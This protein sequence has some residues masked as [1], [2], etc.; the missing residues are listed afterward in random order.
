MEEQ[1][2]DL[3]A[4]VAQIFT[5]AGWTAGT[6]DGWNGQFIWAGTVVGGIDPFGTPRVAGLTGPDGERP[7]VVASS[8]WLVEHAKQFAP[9]ITTEATLEPPVI[10][11]EQS[12]EPEESLGDESNGETGEEAQGAHQSHSSGDEASLAG[13]VE[14]DSSEGGP[15]D[16]RA[17]LGDEAELLDG[18]SLAP[19]DLPIDADF[20]EGQ[21]LGSELLDVE[22]ELS[23]PE[24]PSPDPE[25]F[26]PDEFAHEP[27][28]EPPQDRFI[29]LDDLDRVRSLRI[30]DVATEALRLTTLIEQA[31]SEQEGEF[32][33]IQAYVVSHL[34]KHTGAFTPQD[35]ASR[36]TYGRFLEL[37]SARSKIA[38]ID[39]RRKDATAFLLRADREQ[40]L[41]FGVA[42]AFA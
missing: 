41:S 2:R 20:T 29:G 27:E 11:L 22:S 9:V 24:L 17:D 36:A 4:E 34:D 35:D 32:S 15:D 25:D 42:A 31:V 26:A 14:V 7:E 28:P 3:P 40:V 39:A 21:D 19:T 30:G 10:V 33:N 6:K 37:S 38:L 23:V 16:Y 12:E 18:G 8:R 5:D 13:L 1:E